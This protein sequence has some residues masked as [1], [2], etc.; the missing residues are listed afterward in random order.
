MAKKGSKHVRTL[1]DKKC[2]LSSVLACGN[3][4]GESIPPLL[5]HPHA[6]LSIADFG[7]GLIGNATVGLSRKGF[8]T[9]QLFQQWFSTNFLQYANKARPLLLILD[10]HTTHIDVKVLKEAK[11]NDVIMICIPP[12]T[13]H[14]FQ[15]LDVGVFHQMKEYFRKLASAYTREHIEEKT[16]VE[17]VQ[18]LYIAHQS[19]MT[20]EHLKSG[21]ERACIY[22]CDVEKAVSKVKKPN[23]E[24]LIDSSKKKPSKYSNI[25]KYLHTN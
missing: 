12:H 25:L 17:F 3:A 7:D 16:Q 15:P 9:Q 21:F 2:T 11:Q 23:K 8:V 19:S 6:R 4:K 24:T 14:L 5:I 1:V 22:P 10:N 20:E 13:S 18:F